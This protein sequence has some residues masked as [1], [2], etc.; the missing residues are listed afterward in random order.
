MELSEE[1][2][3]V[4]FLRVLFSLFTSLFRTDFNQ[5]NLEYWV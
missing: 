3:K 5:T 4:G 1:V 2:D